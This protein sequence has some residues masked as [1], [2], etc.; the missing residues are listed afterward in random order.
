MTLT[1]KFILLAEDDPVVAEL[2]IN[3]LRLNEPPP[4]IVHVRDGVQALNFLYAREEFAG[5]EPGCPALVLLDIKMPRLDG[6][7]VLR[8]IKCD[9][10]LSCIPV[11]MLTSSQ[12]ERDVRAGYQFGANAF[13]V[14]PV[15]YRRLVG[16][17]QALEN[18]WLR[19]NQPPPEL[20]PGARK[21]E[22]TGDQLA[23]HRHGCKS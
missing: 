3:G 22:N 17:L 8:Q 2:V 15:E 10:R 7:E 13:V 6:L 14:K 9:D 1:E 4:K 18:F 23:S 11:V 12:D 20:R 5:R 21:A 19:I 16:V